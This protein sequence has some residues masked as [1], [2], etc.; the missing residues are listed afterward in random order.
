MP[1][2][3]RFDNYGGID[4][5]RV[6]DVPRPVP[7]EGQVL[8]QVKAAGINPGEDKIRVDTIANFDAVE[9]YGVKAEGSAFAAS[10]RSWPS[11]P[12]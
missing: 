5:L 9:K 2:A 3:V 11:W 6:E 4:L 12:R 1:K 8:V 7:G 10:A